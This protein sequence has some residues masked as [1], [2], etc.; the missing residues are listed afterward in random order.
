MGAEAPS[1]VTTTG[2]C[3]TQPLASYHPTFTPEPQSATPLQSRS[4]GRTWEGRNLWKPQTTNN[5]ISIEI[6]I[7]KFFLFKMLPWERKGF[8]V[9]AN[10]IYGGG[11]FS[12]NLILH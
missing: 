7:L 4:S 9:K 2:S 3:K 6:V 5:V 8:S 12:M 1:A 11:V 10:G